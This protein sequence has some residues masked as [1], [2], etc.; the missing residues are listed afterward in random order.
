MK[1]PDIVNL[2]LKLPSYFHLKLAHL[3][4]Q[5]LKKGRAV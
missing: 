3:A 5:F 2:G 4:I 1:F